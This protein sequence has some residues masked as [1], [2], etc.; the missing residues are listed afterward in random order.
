MQWKLP[1]T[2]SS[3]V[4]RAGRAA[5]GYGTS[6]LAVLLVEKS[7]F[8][9]DITEAVNKTKSTKRKGNIRE[10]TEYPKSKDKIYAVN[11]G[12]SRGAF[13]GKSDTIPLRI[14]VPLDSF[15]LDEGLYTLVQTTECRRKVLTMIYANEPP[16]EWSVKHNF[17]TYLKF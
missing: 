2:V 17:D 1:S 3:F 13:G 12:V 7:A 14:A 6:G 8:D 4:Q 16:G 10:A 9:V 11:H 5:R 15:S